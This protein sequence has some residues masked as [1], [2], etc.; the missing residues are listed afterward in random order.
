M[1]GHNCIFETFRACR[2]MLYGS[3]AL[4][5]RDCLCVWMT[6]S[7]SSS[8]E[9]HENNF[10]WIWF[11][12]LSLS[13][14][15]I[16]VAPTSNKQI[17]PFRLNRQIPSE[18]CCWLWIKTRLAYCCYTAC[19]SVLSKWRCR[20]GE[21]VNGETT[22]KKWFHSRDRYCVLNWWHGIESVHCYSRPDTIHLARLYSL[23]VSL[24][25]ITSA[26]FFVNEWKEQK[27]KNYQSTA[28]TC[29]Y[30]LSRNVSIK[31]NAFKC[32]VCVCNGVLS[33]EWPFLKQLR[34][35]RKTQ[36]HNKCTRTARTAE[37]ILFYIFC[38]ILRIGLERH[39]NGKNCTCWLKD[40]HFYRNHILLLLLLFILFWLGSEIDKAMRILMLKQ[41]GM[42]MSRIRNSPFFIRNARMK[43]RIIRMKM[44]CFVVLSK[45]VIRMN[46]WD[47]L[48]FVV[49]TSKMAFRF[50]VCYFHIR[51]SFVLHA[52]KFIYDILIHNLSN[53]IEMRRRSQD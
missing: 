53:A 44:S 43:R 29:N 24:L 36:E 18:I 21:W 11:L 41:T 50:F 33:V 23:S 9:M 6:F 47:E 1:P 37:D 49:V 48:I 2:C 31:I 34:E 39:T 42:R 14:E 12:C 13:L 28:T 3:F 46:V 32:V 45:R 35:N 16:S 27:K 40:R 17:V 19:H 52:A 38:R 10:S 8:M 15:S 25:S 5:C 26:R 20:M 4:Q 51:R 30:N 22:M 7:P